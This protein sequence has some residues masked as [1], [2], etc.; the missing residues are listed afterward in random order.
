MRAW[1]TRRRRH[2]VRS[3]L[4]A[5]VALAGGVAATGCVPPPPPPPAV[6]VYGDSL[7]HESVTE[8]QNRMHAAFPGW[9]VI[10]HAWGG[11]AQCD[12]HSD[13]VSDADHHNV[14]VA[15]LAFVGNA[16]TPCATSRPYPASYVTDANWAVDLY[17]SRGIR[18]AFVATPG[19]IGITPAERNI[20]NVYRSVGTARGVPVVD[21][22]DLFVD[23]ATGRYEQLGPCLVGECT[24]YVNLRAPDGG[25]LC[26]VSGQVPCAVYS[27]GVVRYVDPIV[28]M[29]TRL[30]GVAIP[31]RRVMSVA[32]PPVTPLPAPTA[33]SVLPEAALV[34]GQPIVPPYMPWGDAPP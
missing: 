5:T 11:L 25:H 17:A 23:P 33:V 7:V 2:L 34:P 10:I 20:P 24:G 8:I 3:L 28:Q 16:G 12:L 32:E 19:H 15:I 1:A 6:A 30:G 27:S 31:P 29:A 21:Y 9:N 14:R 4:L 13:M 22:D 18:L 26:P